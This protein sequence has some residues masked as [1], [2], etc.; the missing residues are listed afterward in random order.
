MIKVTFHL[1]SLGF[2]RV[3]GFRVYGSLF[4]CSMLV[5]LFMLSLGFSFSLSIACWLFDVVL[6]IYSSFFLCSLFLGLLM[7]SLGFGVLFFCPMLVGPIILSLRFR[8]LF[9]FV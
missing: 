4:L 7:L 2:F 8:V 9:F 1:S 5:G 3:L 6:R